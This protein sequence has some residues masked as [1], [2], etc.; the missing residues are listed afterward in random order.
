MSR[1]F[2]LIT[3]SIAVIAAHVAYAQKDVAA[4]KPVFDAFAKEAVTPHHLFGTRTTR[5]GGKPQ[6]ME[7]ISAG[8]QIYLMSDGHWVRSPVTATQMAAQEQDNIRTATVYSCH[9]LR[10][11]AVGGEAAVVYGTHSEN[12]GSKFDTQVWVAK[13]SGLVLR[14]ESDLDPGDV[15]QTHVSTRYEYTNVHPPAGV[16]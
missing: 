10:D 5:T 4:C 7:L 1:R 6:P 3:A 2:T 12:D 14:T 15:D 9:R 13:G 8:G 11:E 16:Q